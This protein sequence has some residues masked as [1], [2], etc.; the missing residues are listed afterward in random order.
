MMT[1]F[2]FGCQARSR[3]HQNYSIS[4]GQ[5]DPWTILAHSRRTGRRCILY[6]SQFS[7][8]LACLQGPFSIKWHQQMT[9][10]ESVPNYKR[11]LMDW[12]MPRH[13]LVLFCHQPVII[14]CTTK[15]KEW[16]GFLPLPGSIWI[17]RRQRFNAR[18]R[19]SEIP[20]ESWEC[21]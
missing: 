21:C 15:K 4:K 8:L 7:A 19:P 20:W 17:R 2:L 6:G 1:T 5:R 12:C 16:F 9:C 18:I 11:V 14:D 13:L 10:K 3:L